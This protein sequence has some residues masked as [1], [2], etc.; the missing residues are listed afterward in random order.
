MFFND[1]NN[2]NNNNNNENKRSCVAIK[3][4]VVKLKKLLETRSEIIKDFLIGAVL[5]GG[6]QNLT[7]N[8]Q[9]IF[10]F[11]TS[12]V[13][14]IRAALKRQKIRLKKLEK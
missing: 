6:S 3:A 1:N 14:K 10:A 9:L 2:N 13:E 11:L 4:R 7:H 5:E 12:S 8:F